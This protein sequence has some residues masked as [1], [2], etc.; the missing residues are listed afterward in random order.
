VKYHTKQY[1]DYTIHHFIP[2]NDAQRIIEAILNKTYRLKKTLKDSSRSMVYQIDIDHEV[3]IFKQ[4]VE[5]NTRKWIRFTTLMRKSE[6]LQSCLSMVKLQE[7]N[8][9]TNKPLVVLE[10]KVMG[11]VIDSWYIC[12]YVAGDSCVESDYPEVIDTLK[13]IHN[14]G[15]LHGDPQ[16]RNFL[17]TK[18]GIQVIDTKLS[19]AWNA[20]QKHLEFV[21]LN[22][23]INDANGYIDKS[24]IGYKLAK[25]IMNDIQ[26]GFR[27]FKQRLRQPFNS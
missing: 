23:S 25:F 13:V 14:A 24:T 3:L 18:S 17:K 1:L 10:K 12:S 8:I 4:P 27:T 26:K 19:Y 22:N 2:W 5:K 20:L 21:Y 16:I 9:H 11:L 6:A 7:I 15:Y